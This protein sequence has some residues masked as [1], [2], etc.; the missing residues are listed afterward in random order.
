[1]CAIL[2]IYGPNVIILLYL[3]IS[4]PT[5]PKFYS[6]R[7]SLALTVWFFLVAFFVPGKLL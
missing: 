5:I 4:F 2:P 3:M 6:E 7:M 1:M